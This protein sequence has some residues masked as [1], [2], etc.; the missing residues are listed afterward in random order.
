[1][2]KWF[3]NAL[4]MHALLVF[5][6]LNGFYLYLAFRSSAIKGRSR[7]SSISKATGYGLELDT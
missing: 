3:W 2:K 1:M 5:E 4:C 6:W 7:E